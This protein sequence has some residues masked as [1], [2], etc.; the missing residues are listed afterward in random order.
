MDKSIIDLSDTQWFTV[1][2]DPTT[3]GE[4]TD[5]QSPAM[6]IYARAHTYTLRVAFPPST[7][8][9]GKLVRSQ[10]YS[11]PR[12]LLETLPRVRLPL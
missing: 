1:F 4:V 9:P 5:L 11:R 3:R 7:I 8:K 6:G 12:P 10:R 2:P